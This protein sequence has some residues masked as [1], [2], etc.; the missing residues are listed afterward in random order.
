GSRIGF[1]LAAAGSAVGL[2]NIWKFPYVTGENGGGIFVLIYLACV[3]LVGLPVMIAEILIGRSTQNSPVGA[4]KSLAGPRSPWVGMGWLSVLSSFV[5]L[6]FYSVVAGWSLHYAW[7]SI[8]GQLAGLGPDNLAP[9]FGSLHASAGANLFWHLVFMGLTIAVIYGGVSKGVERW[10]RILMPALLIMMLV[11]LIN[12]LTLDGFGKAFQFTAGGALEALG[13][14]FFSLSLGMGAM[15]TYGSYLRR[16]DDVVGAS[17]TISALDTCIALVASLMLF[18]IIFSYGMEP[19]AGPGLVFIS[20]PI[21]LSQMPGTTFLATL[22]FGL[23]VFAALTSAISMLE[24]A[25]S[26]FIDQRGWKRHRAAVAAGL[27]FAILGMPAALSG[28]TRLFG[29]GMEALVGKNWFDS[30]DY[31]VTNW[32]LPLGGLGIAL[33]TA[34]RMDRRLRQEEFLS[35][36]RL[37]PFYQGWVFLLKFPVP[38]AILLVFLHAVG[39]L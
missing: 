31:L 25:T 5:L 19:A 10:S 30:L 14:A 35:G 13:Q 26:Y 34:W 18:P 33:F 29:S 38:V 20:V 37:R 12:S 15:L 27:T 3:L 39:L 16:R 8:S 22:F 17:V 9:L 2:G 32:M 36:S 28:G 6:S 1:I 21:A 7:L 4:F 23:L 24:V 11:L